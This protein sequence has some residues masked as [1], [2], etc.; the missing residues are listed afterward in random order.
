M[1]EKLLIRQLGQARG[2]VGYGVECPRE[3][4]F[5]GQVTVEPLVHG[6]LP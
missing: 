5:E 3:K 4:I 1:R 6:M 2:G